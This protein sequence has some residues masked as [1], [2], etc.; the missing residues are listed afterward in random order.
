MFAT[1][2]AQSY[3]GSCPNIAVS[4]PNSFSNSSFMHRN[5]CT[6]TDGS[7]GGVI[8]L[9]P[10]D[11][12]DETYP[13]AR[14]GCMGNRMLTGS[15]RCSAHARALLTRRC[16]PQG[17]VM[18]RLDAFLSGS[19]SSRVGAH[20]TETAPG[21]GFA[22]SSGISFISDGV[23]SLACQGETDGLLGV[24]EDGLT[25]AEVRGS[26]RE[27]HSLGT[28]CSPCAPASAQRDSFAT[29]PRRARSAAP[30]RRG[31]SFQPL[32]HA[33]EHISANALS[34]CALTQLPPPRSTLPAVRSLTQHHHLDSAPPGLFWGTTTTTPAWTLTC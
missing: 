28:R 18:A 27:R 3:F 9:A 5:N 14:R 33:R 1:F 17:S 2:D 19:G 25:G 32:G 13:K 4:P 7:F 22:W 21:A 24:D 11:D 23:L 20:A 26:T 29:Q 8:D 10:V 6:C 34:A 30:A 16:A 15:S 12:L 31:S